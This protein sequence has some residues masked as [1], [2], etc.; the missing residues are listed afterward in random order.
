MLRQYQDVETKKSKLNILNQTYIQSIRNLRNGPGFTGFSLTGRKFEYDENSSYV[1][2]GLPNMGSTC[3]LASIFQCLNAFS[4]PLKYLVNHRSDLENIY[5]SYAEYQLLNSYLKLVYV[6]F[7]TVE[8]N[9]NILFS[10]VVNEFFRLYSSSKRFNSLFPMNTQH[11]AHEFLINYISYIDE[12]IVEMEIAKRGISRDEDFNRIYREYEERYSFG[13]NNF[14]FEFEIYDFCTNDDSHQFERHEKGII[15]TLEIDGS[16]TINE[17]LH[18]S[19]NELVFFDCAQCRI[20]NAKFS[21]NRF[22]RHLQDNF[23]VQLS[24]FKVIDQCKY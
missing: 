20:K 14:G 9:R 12:C 3:Y 15:F 11:D 16:Q 10:N 17:C 2:V 23:I 22:F 4:S 5:I 24:R 18:K 8:T 6:G 21:R 19:F 7:N 1:K 13:Y